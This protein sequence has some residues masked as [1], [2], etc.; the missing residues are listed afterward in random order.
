M[1]AD[2]F[3][4]ILITVAGMF[5]AGFIGMVSAF[6]HVYGRALGDP[7]FWAAVLRQL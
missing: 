6:A 7:R 5:S 2:K 1:R 3:K 4:P